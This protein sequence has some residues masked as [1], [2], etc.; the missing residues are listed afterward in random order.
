MFRRRCKISVWWGESRASKPILEATR[1]VRMNNNRLS[2]LATALNLTQQKSLD[3]KILLPKAW[4]MEGRITSRINN[5]GTVQFYFKAKHHLMN[6][7]E[8]GPWNCNNWMVAIDRWIRRDEPDFLLTISFCVKILHIPE[9]YRSDEIIYEVGDILGIVDE[10]KITEATADAD[11]EVWIHVRKKV[12]YRLIFIRYLEFEPGQLTMVRFFYKK[13]RKFYFICGALTHSDAV[14]HY[15]GIPLPHIGTSQRHRSLVPDYSMEELQNS[16]IHP[17][18][19]IIPAQAPEV[20]SGERY[21]VTHSP[22]HSLN[23]GRDDTMGENVE[24][25]LHNEEQVHQHEIAGT[26]FHF[27]CTSGSICAWFSSSR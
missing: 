6:V 3:L 1:R 25:N 21:H 5:D 15:E 10:I 13:L 4:K 9:E 16:P 23:D 17:I 19:T 18:G 11:S 2:L 20:A 22:T 7:L 12:N 27:T 14:C 24:S 26:D 8:H